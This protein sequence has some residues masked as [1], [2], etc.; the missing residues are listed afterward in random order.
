MEHEVIENKTQETGFTQIPN[1]ILNNQDLSWGAKGLW[2]YMAGKPVGWK[3]TLWLMA[4]HC[5]DGITSTNSRLKELMQA[6]LV[7]REIVMTKSGKKCF[8][9]IFKKPNMEKPNM[10]KPNMENHTLEYSNIYKSNKKYSNK[11]KRSIVSKETMD[12]PQ[13]S[14]NQLKNQAPSQNQT[15]LSINQSQNYEPNPLSFAIPPSRKK[16]N[17]KELWEQEFEELWKLY[18]RKESKANGLKA[19]LKVRRR[20]VSKETILEGLKRYKQKVESEHTERKYI[21]KGGNWFGGERWEDEVEIEKNK[22]TEKS[23]S[24]L[25]LS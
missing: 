7:K 16:A 18:P 4:N 11:E 19:Y 3:F 1:E 17:E 24:K 2:A 9:S 6:G 22:Q 13:N 8:Y 14:K 25:D 5:K 15:S 23:P 12:I 20:G 10:E 21:I